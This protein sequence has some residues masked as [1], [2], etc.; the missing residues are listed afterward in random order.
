MEGH[1]VYRRR[2]LPH[3]DMPGATYFVTA[4]LNGSITAEGLLDLASYRA[5]LPRLPPMKKMSRADWNLRCWKKTFARSDDWLDRQPAVRHFA[6]PLLA[7]I[8]VDACLFWAGRRYD[9]LAYAVMPSRLHWVFRPI[10]EQLVDGVIEKAANPVVEQVANL[11]EPLQGGKRP[12]RSPR[13]RIMHTLKLHTA[14]KCN[15][16]LGRCGALWQAESYDHCVRDDDE[17]ERIIQ[18]VELNPVKARLVSQP[19]QWPFSS[20]FDRAERGLLLGQ[21][22]VR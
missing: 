2:R 1:G 6:N 21:P 13:E 3:W 19:E 9:L 12:A 17:L 20:A 14:S 4:C 10:Q 22:I 11:L 8:V 5:R 15:R 7:T 18:Y 16:Q